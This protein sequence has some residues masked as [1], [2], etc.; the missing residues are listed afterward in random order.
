M[1]KAR[2]EHESDEDISNGSPSRPSLFSSAN[3]SIAEVE[4]ILD[5][6]EEESPS[7]KRKTAKSF[8][9]H[10]AEVI[11]VDEEQAPPVAVIH[12]TE[13]IEP[14]D[15][16]KLN[17]KPSTPVI[18]LS[19]PSTASKSLFGVK[20]SA[21]KEPSKLRY[22]YQADK[23]EVLG[24]QA[25][26]T[27]PSFP[28]LFTP[29]PSAPAHSL[30]APTPIPAKAKLSPKAE[31]LAMSADELP[32]FCLTIKETV[33]PAGP[34]SQKARKASLNASVSALPTFD[35]KTMPP[36]RAMNGFNWTEAG[37][38]LPDTTAQ[39]WTCTLCCL[40]NPES[41]K[42]KCTICEAPRP[43]ATPSEPPAA[44]LSTPPVPP[45]PVQAFD[46]SAAG[47]A[48]LSKPVDGSWNCSLCSLANPASA[49][50]KCTVCDAPR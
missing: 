37:L 45:P 40:E 18:P 36:P 8:N 14:G 42:E 9:L 33:Y 29:P 23:V 11:E 22:S 2:T 43:G 50:E 17:G 4:E 20:S 39:M 19:P 5:A 44:T 27:L 13:V 15:A 47:L 38:K 48:P 46:W 35:I 21:P 24:S 34:S 26:P 10:T 1:D 3:K 25:E 41:A 12:P 28:S 31:V 16:P 7:K 6:D 32:T 30:A 49:T